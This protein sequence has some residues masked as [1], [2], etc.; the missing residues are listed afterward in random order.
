MDQ[1]VRDALKAGSVIDITTTV[2]PVDGPSNVCQVQSKKLL[3]AYEVA[4]ARFRAPIF[5]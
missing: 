1:Q 5:A 2:E 4:S 3:S